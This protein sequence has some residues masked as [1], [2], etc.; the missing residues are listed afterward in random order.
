MLPIFLFLTIFL[1]V[2]AVQAIYLGFFRFDISTQKV[3]VGLENFA[4]LFRER[5][6]LMALRNTFL[7]MLGIVPLSLMLSLVIA[8]ALN[9][10]CRLVKA[11][12][13]GAFY[14]PIVVSGVTLSLIWKF[15]YD[16]VIGIANHLLGMLGLERVIWLGSTRSAM[17]AIMAV[18]F[19]YSLG[20]P[21]ILFMAALAGIPL[22]YYEAARIDG[23]GRI[24]QFFSITLPLL[25]PTTLYLLVQGTISVFQTFV[26]IKLL[27]TG[28]PNNATQTLSY[29]LYEKAFVSGD[30]GTACAIGVVLFF[31][32][33]CI[34]VI[35]YRWLSND[36]E[37]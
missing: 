18:V 16:P 10:S 22:T 15:I 31:I 36:I 17:P 21:V 9:D 26:I 30:Y 12:A 34:A 4:K 33:T 32:V 2:P 1:I 29:L 20:R 24:R 14:L 11:F 35:Q 25:K 3:F 19:S 37:Y 7:L 8:V 5:A 6:F 13:R 28:G 23:A 27:T